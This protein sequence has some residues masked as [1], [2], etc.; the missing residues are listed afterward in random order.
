MNERTDERYLTK[1]YDVIVSFVHVHH[2]CTQSHAYSWNYC[3]ELVC[4][5]NANETIS[6][7]FVALLI[8]NMLN[9]ILAIYSIVFAVVPAAHS[10]PN[11]DQFHSDRKREKEW[12]FLLCFVYVF[13]SSVNGM[14]LFIFF[15]FL[16]SL[17]I[18][19]E[20]DVCWC[21][22]WVCDEVT[23]VMFEILIASVYFF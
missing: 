20:R 5:A 22:V 16:L 7:G 13:V 6:S 15:Y 11:H 9:T 8:T 18:V 3:D 4:S 17:V 14:F 21:S 23:H 2:L 19:C 12:F 10:V 1:C